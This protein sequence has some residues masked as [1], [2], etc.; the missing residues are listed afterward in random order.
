MKKIIA[1]DDPD[2]RDLIP[3]FLQSRHKDIK[4][5]DAVLKNADNPYPRSS[6]KGS[7]GG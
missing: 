6:M 4:S 3:G 7:E 2:L 1:H 5:I